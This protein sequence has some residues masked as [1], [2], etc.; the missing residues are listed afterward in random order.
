MNKITLAYRCLLTLIVVL[1][2]SSCREKL[3]SHTAFV[4]WLDNPSNNLVKEQTVGAID[5]K[6]K[7]L[8]A[9]YLGYE[10]FIGEE[11]KV[12]NLDSLINDY[13]QSLTFLFTI[14]PK[15][16]V[17]NID[18]L[19]AGVANYGEFAYRV[20]DLNFNLAEYVDLKVGDVYYKPVL[21][22]LEDTYGIANHRNFY[23]VFAPTEQA[24][25]AIKESKEFTFRFID[26]IFATGINQFHFRKIDI[27][28]IPQLAYIKNNTIK[29]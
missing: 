14:G 13:N 19:K 8:P 6:V 15:D 2:L 3:S 1:G 27:T 26:G 25:Q 7:Y 16:G 21:T 11:D 18:V 20:H 5:L 9:E 24:P 4:K 22:R 10:E 23:V 29:R 17:E 12:L 28:N